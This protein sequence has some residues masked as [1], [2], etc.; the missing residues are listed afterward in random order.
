M[1][2]IFSIYLAFLILTFLVIS[3][4]KEPRISYNYNIDIPDENFKKALLEYYV[5]E[6]EYNLDANRDGEISDGEAALVNDLYLDDNDIKDLTGIS[7][8]VNL[9]YL[10]ISFNQIEKLDLSNNT[11][12][13]D[14]VCGRNVIEELNLNG[15]QRLSSLH[16][17]FNNLKNIDLSSNTDLGSFYCGYNELENIDLSNNVDLKYLSIYGNQ[18]SEIDLAKNLKLTSFQFHDNLFQQIDLSYLPI[19][20]GI[21]IGGNQF[22]RIDISDNPNITF[23]RL[24]GEEPL[25]QEIC[26]Y[27]MEYPTEKLHLV[28]FEDYSVFKFCD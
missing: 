2:K 18:F 10:D 9:T 17:S 12:L 23:I 3:C 25:L 16:C 26:V 15:C 19:L 8:F 13:R 1:L 5:I 4:D 28:G 6:I 27:E 11:K 22:V 24:E 20:S 21:W 14:L 7:A